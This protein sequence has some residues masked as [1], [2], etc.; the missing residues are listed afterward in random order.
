MRTRLSHEIQRLLHILQILDIL[1]DLKTKVPSW[2]LGKRLA[3]M[4]DI[5]F[6]FITLEPRFAGLVPVI[7]GRVQAMGIDSDLEVD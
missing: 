7:T 6:Q 4:K 1:N 5:W 2:I 3:P